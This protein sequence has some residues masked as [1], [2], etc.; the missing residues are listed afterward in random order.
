MRP[1][2]QA[3]AGLFARQ[4]FRQRLV[5]MVRVDSGQHMSAPGLQN[6]RRNQQLADPQRHAG[7]AQLGHR[8]IDEIRW[9]P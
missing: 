7:S 8:L 6:A 5:T 1:P 9:R 4:S 3:L 2:E